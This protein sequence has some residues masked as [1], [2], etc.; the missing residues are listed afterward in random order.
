MNNLNT[1][2]SQ[3]F[4][5]QQMANY[6]FNNKGLQ[7]NNLNEYQ[8]LNNNFRNNNNNNNL[9][10]QNFNNSNMYYKNNNYN[11][12]NN[13]NNDGNKNLQFQEN[14]NNRNQY[15]FNQ[16]NNNPYN[17]IQNNQNHDKKSF[18]NDQSQQNQKNQ[19]DELSIAQ[20]LKYVSEKYPQLININQNSSGMTNNAI[21]QD[22]PRYYVIKSFT[23]EDIHKV[24]FAINNLVDKI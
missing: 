1:M 15:Q 19:P 13:H 23:E 2:N 5:P 8:N 4:N 6:Y 12:Q 16:N 20:S 9:N 18:Q 10:N 22:F 24:I 21:A 17:Q 3:N 11:N 7:T 14:I